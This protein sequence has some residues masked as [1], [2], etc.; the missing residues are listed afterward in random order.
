MFEDLAFFAYAAHQQQIEDLIDKLAVADETDDEF[1]LARSVGLNLNNL[2]RY[3]ID[4][5]NRE[6]VRRS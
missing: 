4:Y 2:T 1:A 6:V 3:E 5:I